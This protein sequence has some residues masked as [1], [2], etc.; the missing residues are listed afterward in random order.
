MT[1]LVVV[2]GLALAVAAMGFTVA[3]LRTFVGYDDDD[4]PDRASEL[5]KVLP[6]EVTDQVRQEQQDRRRR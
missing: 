2:V 6:R 4:D 5:S 1:W 3:C